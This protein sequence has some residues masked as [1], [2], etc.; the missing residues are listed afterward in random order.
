MERSSRGRSNRMRRKYVWVQ[1]RAI[2]S[3][4][5]PRNSPVLVL[6]EL[7]GGRAQATADQLESEAATAIA[8]GADITDESACQ[9]LVSESIERLG[10][11]D[12]LVNNAGHFGSIVGSPFTNFTG[13]EWDSNYDIHVKG[14]FFLCKA[15]APHMIERRYGR[16]VNISSAAEET[17]VRL[18]DPY[19]SRHLP[20][21]KPAQHTQVVQDL[22]DVCRG[23]A[24]Q[25]KRVFPGFPGQLFE[26]RCDSG[27]QPEPESANLGIV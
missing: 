12:I 18:L 14:P 24:S 19:A 13:E 23:V 16:I 11:I 7:S 10:A 2:Q 9:D 21:A 8:I 27:M 5:G 1:Y 3:P 20:V 25:R 26:D 15:L 17:F 4:I 22:G 6:I